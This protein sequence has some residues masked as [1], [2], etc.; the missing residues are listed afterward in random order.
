VPKRCG[1]SI[2]RGGH[3]PQAPPAQKP[4]KSIA[5]LSHDGRRT[6]VPREAS[7]CFAG[8]RWWLSTA[9][10]TPVEKVQKGE[11]RVPHRPLFLLIMGKLDFWP[12]RVRP[13]RSPLR[14]ERGADSS[15]PGRGAVVPLHREMLLRLC[16]PA[17]R[18]FALV[19]RV[20]GPISA[21]LLVGR[22]ARGSGAAAEVAGRTDAMSVFGEESGK[23]RRKK[24]RK[25]SGDRLHVWSGPSR[26]TS[27][28]CGRDRPTR[29]VR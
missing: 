4:G 2:L 20:R 15:V 3:F 19:S 7:R 11:T 21:A 23:K 27:R 14:Q 8:Q 18:V 5:F 24:S 1:H 12:L 28:T 25:G 9:L 22:R 6:P 17:P 29:A 16:G 13:R 10:S 26:K